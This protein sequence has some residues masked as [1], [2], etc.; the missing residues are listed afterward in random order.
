MA[1]ELRPLGFESYAIDFPGGED[2]P[3]L[4][5]YAK[6]LKDTLDGVPVSVLSSY[7][8]TLT[9]ENTRNHLLKLMDAAPLFGVNVISLFAGSMPNSDIPGIIP[10]FKKIFGELTRKAEDLN[11]K[12]AIEGCSMG[13]TW[14]KGGGLNIGYCPDAWDLMF[15][16]V[17]SDKLGLE[18]EPCHAL[19]MLMDPIPQLRRYVKKV[20]HV[21]AKDGTIAWDVLAE[22]GLD[23]PHP[24]MWNRTPGFGD[25]N[26]NDIFTIL[27]QNGY[28]GYADI[29]GYHDPVHYA[30]TEFSG[31]LRAL[32]YLKDCRGGRQ[33]VPGPEAYRG[34]QKPKAG[35]K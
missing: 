18:W 35:K 6:K 32:N 26:W 28:S 25:T 9:D 33:F 22:H 1:P 16:A 3:D 5:E 4:G 12:L 2:L 7:G 10:A 30:D 27:L 15:D 14:R 21:H 29:E 20:Y 31:Q 17:P 11:L 19:E 8:N 23:S 13:T 34:Y 24:Y